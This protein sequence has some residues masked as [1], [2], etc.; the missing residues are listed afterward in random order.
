MLPSKD[1]DQER[2]RPETDR[3]ARLMLVVVVLICSDLL[4]MTRAMS[5]HWKNM[6]K[7]LRMKRTYHDQS[8]ELW[9]LSQI[10]SNTFKLDNHTIMLKVVSKT[11][12][13]EAVLTVS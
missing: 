4:G 13:A 9:E 10:I 1:G 8:W 7:F 12:K 2:R 3:D 11:T 6:S 5:N